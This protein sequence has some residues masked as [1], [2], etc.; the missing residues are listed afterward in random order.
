MTHWIKQES[1]SH[2][3]PKEINKREEKALLHSETW[4]HEQRGNVRTGKSLKNAQTMYASLIKNRIFIIVSKNFPTNYLLISREMRSTFAVE[5]SGRHHL[6]QVIK[7]K[8]H[9]YGNKSTACAS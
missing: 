3:K 1:M 8:C 9:Q 2:Y 6:N 4:T 7:V 5:K